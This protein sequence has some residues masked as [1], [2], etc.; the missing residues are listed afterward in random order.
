MDFS[1]LDNKT[2]Q[3]PSFTWIKIGKTVHINFQLLA[4]ALHAHFTTDSPFLQHETNHSS[5]A[6]EITTI[7][8]Q[9]DDSNRAG[10]QTVN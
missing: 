6:V 7:N 5:I 3:P 2:N 4:L 8:F 1:S 10:L 9:T